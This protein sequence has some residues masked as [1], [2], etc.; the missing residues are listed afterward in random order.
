MS[1][2]ELVTRTPALALLVALVAVAPSS[3]SRAPHLQ[4]ATPASLTEE[5][6]A[7]KDSA[8]PDF[9]DED[10]ASPDG[11]KVAWRTSAKGKWS[12]RLNG[13]QQG[14]TYDEV[15]DLT[16]SP[17]SQR[18]VF[19][20][21]RDRK[22]SI[23]EGE[24]ER[25]STYADVGRP[26][27]SEDSRHLAFAAKPAK[28]W[29][30]VVNGRPLGGEFDQILQ[31]VLSR[32]G[33]RVAFVGRRG[34]KLVAVVDGEEGPPFDIIGGFAFSADGKRFAYSGVEVHQGFGKQNSTGR[35]IIDGTPSPG[36]DGAQVGGLLKSM[37]TG[38]T[39]QL[40]LGC[41]RKLLADLHGV[42]APVFSPDGSRV[43]YA[44]RRGENATM[45]VADGTEGPTFASIREGPV[46]SPDGQHIALVMSDAGSH[47][48]V[49][50]GDRV[51]QGSTGETDH[52]T[53]LTLAPDGRRAA[54]VGVT[55][56]TFFDRGETNRA[57]RRVYVD[58]IAGSEYNAINLLWLQFSPVGNHLVYVV[59]GPSN[60]SRYT[61][62]I[63]VDGVEGKRYD[64]VFGTPR[65]D[66]GGGVVTYTAVAGRRYY[67]VTQS[68]GV[69]G[70]F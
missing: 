62:F 22:W 63:V 35:V 2:T 13:T 56:G 1:G 46:F 32:D 18:L 52:F 61:S 49:I 4:G 39:E 42:T 28:K 47:A 57:R 16:F 17:D 40:Q 45:V 21:K 8:A 60:T 70:T 15:R 41:F 34:S 48:L 3:T 54:Y 44:A 30:L 31:S 5:L 55:G 20:A 50:D 24:E 51:G 27:F 23:V 64:D 69:Q 26:T 67:F 9:D 38:A 25:G 58:G 43:V 36:F 37:A 11:R 29:T 19:A 53:G 59:A 66:P 12:V 68:L 10:V 6:I 14:A 7:E 65:F 33:Q